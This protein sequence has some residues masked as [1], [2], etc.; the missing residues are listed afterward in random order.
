MFPWPTPRPKEPG[1]SCQGSFPGNNSDRSVHGNPGQVADT[2]LMA[3]LCSTRLACVATTMPGSPPRVQ[4]RKACLPWELRFDGHSPIP[5]P[6]HTALAPTLATTFPSSKPRCRL[7]RPRGA[8]GQGFNTTTRPRRMQAVM[9]TT[10]T[11][12]STFAPSPVLATPPSRSSPTAHGPG[13]RYSS[14]PLHLSLVQTARFSTAHFSISLGILW[15]SSTS[16]FDSI[17]P[18]FRKTA[19]WQFES[20]T[21]T[22]TQSCTYRRAAPE[23]AGGA[24]PKEEHSVGGG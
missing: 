11:S 9:P 12:P 24:C 21:M 3:T 10:P 20:P 6:F 5:C 7:R 18:A 1:I 15:D 23:R 19:D 22:S 2:S 13:A 17:R 4:R 14:T 16:T 8:A